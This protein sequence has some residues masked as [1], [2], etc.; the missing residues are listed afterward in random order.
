[1]YINSVN[2]RNPISD[3]TSDPDDA[4][5]RNPQFATTRWSQVVAAKDADAPEA[6]P[7]LAS[8]CETYWYSVYYFLRRKGYNHDAAQDL[9]QGFFARLIEKRDFASADPQ[10][11]RFR[12][13]LLAA[14]KHFAANEHDREHAA[15]RGG[16]QPLLSID[17]AA[18]GQMY[19]AEA[20]DHRTPEKAYERRWA[21]LM[22]GRIIEKLRQEYDERGHAQLFDKLQFCLTGEGT[23]ETYAALAAEMKVSESSLKVAIHRLRRRYRE[24]LRQAVADTVADPQDIDDEIQALIQVLSAPA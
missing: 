13:F 11:G 17:A 22:L 2:P 14:V 9:T 10:R 19:A 1:M 16:G 5:S 4:G 8:L 6:G 23:P 15:K 20:V 24:R 18:A 7:A 12:T 21:M 3:P